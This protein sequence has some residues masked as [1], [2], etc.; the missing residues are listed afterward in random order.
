MFCSMKSY[1]QIADPNCYYPNF[2]DRSQVDTIY[3]SY[4]DQQ[5]GDFFRLPPA[6]DQTKSRLAIAGLKNGNARYSIVDPNVQFNLHNLKISDSLYLDRNSGSVAARY[7]GHF[8]NT[9]DLDMLAGAGPP[10]QI[11][12]ADKNGHYDSSRK[13]Y[14]AFDLKSGNYDNGTEGTILPIVT[15]FLSDTVDDIF[16]GVTTNTFKNQPEK[17]TCFLVHYSGGEAM[18]KEPTIILS[19]T[20][21]FFDTGVLAQRD[22]KVGDFRG[23]GKDDIVGYDRYDNLFFYRDDDKFDPV[24]FIRSMHEDTLIAS[25]QQN[26]NRMYPYNKIEFGTAQAERVLSK[27]DYDSSVD[28]IFMYILPAPGGSGGSIGRF[29]FLKGSSTFGSTRIQLDTVATIRDLGTLNPAYSNYSPYSNFFIG[30]IDHSPKANKFIIIHYGEE[31]L[32][33]HYFLYML[34]DAFDDQADMIFEVPYP[35]YR[36][37]SFD[38]I[39]AN[40]DNFNDILFGAPFFTSS[41]SNLNN[42]GTMG[43]IYGTSRIPHIVKSSVS[44]IESSNNYCRILTMPEK[45]VRVEY[46]VNENETAILKIRD[47]L[48]RV[49]LKQ[50]LFLTGNNSLNLD[51]SGIQSGA[52]IFQIEGKNAH[53]AGK[54]YLSD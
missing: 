37:W 25:W 26:L 10:F 14:L 49:V 45:E 40:G 29:A 6:S 44:N 24:E 47:I 17:D 3:G 54:F 20:K 9:K 1:A 15:N 13:T 51:L 48:G 5:L 27:P 12:W 4:T 50:N 2:D 18:Q 35:Y 32:Y 42:V 39:N 41:T 52:Y 43:V 16:Y 46:S 11:Y 23:T 22:I 34:G 53:F 30:Q 28:L 21:F 36:I 38:T 7:Y 19:D 33:E 31:V 8:R